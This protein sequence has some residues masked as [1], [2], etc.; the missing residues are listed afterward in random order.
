MCI[1]CLINSFLFLLFS[2]HIFMY[3]FDYISN[4]H[5]ITVTTN[6]TLYN[7]NFCEALSK[8]RRNVVAMPA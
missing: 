2:F 1:F 6:H 7:V 8:A 5:R 3:K 4:E